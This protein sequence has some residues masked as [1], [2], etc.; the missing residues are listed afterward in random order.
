MKFIFVTRTD[1]KAVADFDVHK[2]GCADL[3]RGG[4]KNYHQY[5]VEDITP[6]AAVK[7]EKEAYEDNGQGGFTF[8]IMPCAEVK[9]E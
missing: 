5:S 8:R 3:S 7:E 9:T 1:S 6:E 4:Y 2:A